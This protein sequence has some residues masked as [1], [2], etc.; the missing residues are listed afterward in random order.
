M[1]PDSASGAFCGR[2]LMATSVTAAFV[3][4]DLV[5]STAIAARLG[6][7]AAEGRPPTHTFVPVGPLELKGLPEPVDAVE[8]LWE[9]A[10][11]DGGVPLPGRLVGAAADALLGFFGRGPELA[12]LH[13]ARKRAHSAKRCQVVF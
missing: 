1:V 11:V 3:F 5:D 2:R 8:V 4:T 7:A 9:P 13:D 6:P 10:K 12:E